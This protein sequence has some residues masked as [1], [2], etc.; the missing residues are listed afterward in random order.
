MAFVKKWKV[1][2]FLYDCLNLYHQSACNGWVNS[3]PVFGGFLGDYSFISNFAV[4]CVMTSEHNCSAWLPHSYTQIFIHSWSIEYPLYSRHWTISPGNS[5]SKESVCNAGDLGS[6][7]GSG[8][9][10]WRMELLP[11]PE[12]CLENSMNRGASWATVHAVTKS[13]TC[14]T[15]WTEAVN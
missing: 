1:S 3:E 13:Q 2:P 5:D 7:P 11:S 9:F 4:I 14:W 6:V 10:P 8:R 12:S 15:G